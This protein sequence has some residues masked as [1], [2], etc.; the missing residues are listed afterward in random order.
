MFNIC[1]YDDPT[2]DFDP[3]V[4]ARAD[5]KGAVMAIALLGCGLEE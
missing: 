5:V 2:G 1:G 3:H 4:Y